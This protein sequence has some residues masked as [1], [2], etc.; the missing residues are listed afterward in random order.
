MRRLVCLLLLIC[1]PLQSFAWRND[2]LQP[3]Q[4]GLAHGIAHAEAQLHHHHDE[5]GSVH[6]DDSD[7]SLKHSG[8]HSCATQCSLIS[9]ELTKFA[10]LKVSLAHAQAPP[11][12]LP[13]PF[14]D[15]PQRPPAFAPG[16]AAGG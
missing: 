4:S 15:D 10:Q 12:A 2:N 7:E 6:F 1:L 11:S 13:N 14:L 3:A 16:L 5:D 8:E 9:G